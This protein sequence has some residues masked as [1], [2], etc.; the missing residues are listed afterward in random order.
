M[1]QPHEAEAKPQGKRV[2]APFDFTPPV[3]PAMPVTKR[4]P[5]RN[6]LDDYIWWGSRKKCI[7]FFTSFDITAFIAFCDRCKAEGRRPPSLPVYFARCVGIVVAHDPWIAAAKHGKG[8][9][10][11][12]DVNILMMVA[13]HT[14]EGED[15]ALFVDIPAAQNKDMAQIA[16]E[17]SDRV[18]SLRRDCSRN[19]PGFQRAAR[20]GRWPT[21]LRRGL[22]LVSSWFPHVRRSMSVHSSYFAITSLSQAVPGRGGWSVPI[23]PAS[24]S[25]ALGGISRRPAVVAGEIVARDFLD[26]TFRMD[27]EIGDGVPTLEVMHRLGLEVESGRLL[28]EYF[29][30]PASKPRKRKPGAKTEE[31]GGNDGESGERE[32]ESGSQ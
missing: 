22:Y 31:A 5:L 14:H 27:H 17:L 3:M 20:F 2:I 24:V 16:A 28:E 8:L 25:V 4:S 18:R 15:M 29:R 21:P 32:A 1:K 6:I 19:S 7:L 12:H 11:P 13:G 10:V 9:Y 26:V 23:L 30:D